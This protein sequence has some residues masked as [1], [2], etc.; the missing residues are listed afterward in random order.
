MVLAPLL[1]FAL[2]LSKANRRAKAIARAGRA[3][4]DAIVEGETDTAEAS[5]APTPPT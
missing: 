4:A 1:V 5:N 3:E 2:L